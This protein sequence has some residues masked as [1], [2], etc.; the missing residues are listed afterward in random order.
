MW[1]KILFTGPMLDFFFSL[2]NRRQDNEMHKMCCAHGLWTNFHNVW[3]G[4]INLRVDIVSV[5]RK[6]QF[7]IYSMSSHRIQPPIFIVYEEKRT[8]FVRNCRNLWMHDINVN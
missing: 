3:I 8:Q 5:C 4:W 7:R 2:H 6:N 1:R